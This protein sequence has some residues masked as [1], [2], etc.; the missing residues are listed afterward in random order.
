MPS[1]TQIAPEIPDVE[2]N[3]P[4]AIEAREVAFL[5]A[6][7][8]GWFRDLAFVPITIA[9]DTHELTI[10]CANDAIAL[11]NDDDAVRAIWTNRGAQNC[12]DWLDLSMLSAAMVDACVASE[13]FHFVP[14]E[15]MAGA[16]VNTEAMVAH[17]RSIDERSGGAKAIAGPWKQWVA[18]P[19]LEQSIDTLP[20]RE[21]SAVQYGAWA[22]WATEEPATALG[23]ATGRKVAQRSTAFHAWDHTDYSEKLRPALKVAILNN[24]VTT[25]AD[26]ARSPDTAYLLSWTGTR[27]QMRHPYLPRCTPIQDGGGCGAPPGPLSGALWG[28]PPPTW[29]PVRPAARAHHERAARAVGLLGR[30]LPL[31]LAGG[32]T[33]GAILYK[34]R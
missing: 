29:E 9:S 2:V 20:E 10:W 12:V 30:T 31:A 23:K 24:V 15:A 14:F 32:L 33:A 27:T 6:V 13:H 4:A 8:N 26:V 17:S 7:A 11:G 16:P 19:A 18:D 28:A 5:G 22:L 34:G 1:W 25:L 21:R 3:S